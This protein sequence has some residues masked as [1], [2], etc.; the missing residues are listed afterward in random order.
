M[1]DPI[2]VAYRVFSSVSGKSYIGITRGSLQQRLW[3]HLSCARRGKERRLYNAIREIGEHSFSIE[4]LA[5]ALGQDARWDTERA[6]IA[7][8]DTYGNG[9]NELPGVP[10]S[11]ADPGVPVCF[12]KDRAPMPVERRERLSRMFKGRTDSPSTK[13]KKSAAQ[14]GNRKGCR[15]VVID[16]QRYD[17]I[18][19]AARELGVS[20]WAVEWKIKSGR[21]FYAER[22]A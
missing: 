9:Y 10:R 6:L 16:G 7:Q 19:V 18:S 15:P 17:G 11:V 3:E 14:R 1:P 5:Y 22:V 13:A 2:Y 21:A 8:W 20:R 4:P 12:T